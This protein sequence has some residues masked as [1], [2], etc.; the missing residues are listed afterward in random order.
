MRLRDTKSCMSCCGWLSNF[1]CHCHHWIWNLTRMTSF[2]SVLSFELLA[3]KIRDCKGIKCISYNPSQSCQWHRF[4]TSIK[5]S[6]KCPMHCPLLTSDKF[7]CVSG[8]E[9]NKQR[10]EARWLGCKKH[11]TDPYILQF[12]MEKEMV[13]NIV[14]VYF[15]NDIHVHPTG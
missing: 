15:C 6:M 4:G 7:S 13:N 2:S 12:C 5:D 9:I 8:L 10:S 1:C 3:T 14:G 11:C